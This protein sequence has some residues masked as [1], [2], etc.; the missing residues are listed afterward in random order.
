MVSQTETD[1]NLIQCRLRALRSDI[2]MIETI[3]KRIEERT[4]GR[5]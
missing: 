2:D 1:I 5:Q 3:L 4:R